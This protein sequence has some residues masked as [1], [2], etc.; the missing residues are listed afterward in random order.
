[1]QKKRDIRDSNLRLY[2]ICVGKSTSQLGLQSEVQQPH[3][4][5]NITL[6]VRTIPTTAC[7]I[8]S[9]V[10]KKEAKSTV[11]SVL[12]LERV[13]KYNFQYTAENLHAYLVTRAPTLRLEIAIQSVIGFIKI[14]TRALFECLR[15]W[16]QGCSNPCTPFQMYR[17]DEME[18]NQWDYIQR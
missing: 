16:P 14:R 10:T 17:F 3:P 4:Y 6:S 18:T 13:H 2:S 1:M 12:G 15:R 8:V 11:P 5:T 7:Q 9:Q